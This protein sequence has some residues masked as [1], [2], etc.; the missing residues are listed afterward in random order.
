DYDRSL[1]TEDLDRAQPLLSHPTSFTGAPIPWKD[2]QKPPLEEVPKSRSNPLYPPVKRRP[3]DLSLKTSDI[4]YAQPK[5]P[6]VSERRRSN[7]IVDLLTNSYQ[8]TSSEVP[9][10]PDFRTT[11][12]C[13]MDCSDI[14]GTWPH[15]LPAKSVPQD[16]MKI[17]DEFRNPRHHSVLAAASASLLNTGSLSARGP[18]ASERAGLERWEVNPL[19]VGQRQGHPLSPRYHLPVAEAGT[20]MHVRFQCER[21]DLGDHPP[22]TQCEE[23]GFIDGSKPKTE[24]RDNGEPQFNLCTEDVPGAQPR[25]RVGVLPVHLYGPPGNRPQSNSLQNADI[26]GAQADTRMTVLRGVLVGG[27][28]DLAA[29]LE[30]KEVLRGGRQ[31]HG[32]NLEARMDALQDARGTTVLHTIRARVLKASEQLQTLAKLRKVEAGKAQRDWER[33]AMCVLVAWAFPELLAEAVPPKEDGARKRG[34]PYA[35]QCGSEVFVEHK[36]ALAEHELLTVAS[37]TNGKVFWAMPATAPLLKDFGIDA[38]H[39]V[40]HKASP[41][42]IEV[43]GSR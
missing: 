18:R 2:V 25:R 13:A 42:W 26:E 19:K 36:D 17:E 3:R 27:A 30:E 12:R 16:P 14:E 24:I 29:L 23:V 39:P 7:C 38:Q 22:P 32:V 40:E 21:H 34:R 31:M 20:S 9:V 1:L 33:K 43:D 6:I 28:E 4:D 11:G 15:P 8:F 41:R 10:Q 35:L 5:K 37:A